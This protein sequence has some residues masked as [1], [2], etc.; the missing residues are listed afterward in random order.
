MN[1]PEVE[2]KFIREEISSDFIG[3]WPSWL[4]HMVL[5]HAFR[6][7]SPRTPAIFLN[8]LENESS[9]PSPI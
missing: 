9:C 7:S 6:G 8:S 2:N 3:V 4:R 1:G 5:I